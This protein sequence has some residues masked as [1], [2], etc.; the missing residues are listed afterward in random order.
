M[1]LCQ[2]ESERPWAPRSTHTR[3]AE[4]GGRCLHSSG[5][6]ER[7]KKERGVRG[8]DGEG[9]EKQ[10]AQDKGQRKKSKRVTE[11]EKGH[12]RV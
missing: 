3:T 10:D 8:D 1:V 2:G 7:E 4:R 9:D 5:S 11:H 12:R 6:S